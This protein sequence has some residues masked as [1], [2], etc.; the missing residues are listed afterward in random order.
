M[1]VDSGLKVQ[2]PQPDGT[3]QSM[4]ETPSVKSPFLQT[5]V[6]RGFYHQC[7][8]IEGLD[9]KLISGE[10]VKGYLGFDGT[11]DRYVRPRRGPAPIPLHALS[12]PLRSPWP[13]LYALNR[14]ASN[15]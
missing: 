11:A 2:L 8:N 5:L 10:I 9:E 3:S 13:D 7:T 15:V 4:N 14:L 6:E 1:A 12:I